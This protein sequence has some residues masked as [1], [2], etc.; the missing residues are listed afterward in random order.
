MSRGLFQGRCYIC[1]VVV[2][3]T[4]C[5]EHR[6]LA[7]YL[8]MPDRRDTITA[9]S[10]EDI[11]ILSDLLEDRERKLDGWRRVAANGSRMATR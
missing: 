10:L 4:Y 3:R 1:G 7:R 2:G 11:D 6:D 5:A 9:P 8:A